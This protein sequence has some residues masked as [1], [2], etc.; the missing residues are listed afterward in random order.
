MPQDNK[1][2]ADYWNDRAGNTWAELQD[3]LDTLLKPLSEA[4]LRAANVQNGERVLDVGCGCGDTSIALA[5]AGGLVQGVDLSQPMLERAQARSD[6]VEF[7]RGDAASFT[8]KQPYDLIF[9]RFGVMFLNFIVSRFQ[10]FALVWGVVEL[11]VGLLLG[12]RFNPFAKTFC[13]MSAVFVS[14]SFCDSVFRM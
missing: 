14:T 9:S 8:P 2:Q 11:C 1:E 5:A 4:G 13:A 10:T 7:I 3:R 12:R 6:Q